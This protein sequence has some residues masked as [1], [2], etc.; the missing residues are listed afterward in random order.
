[1][2]D[3]RRQ[4]LLAMYLRAPAENF[5]LAMQRLLRA[6]PLVRIVPD[7]P[8][9]SPIAVA[10]IRYELTQQRQWVLAATLEPLH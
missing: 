4:N 7:P 8:G 1:M 6:R 10:R 5:E 9:V 3:D 2:T